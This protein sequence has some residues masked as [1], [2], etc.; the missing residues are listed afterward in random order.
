LSACLNFAPKFPLVSSIEKLP[1]IHGG[2]LKGHDF[3][4][5]KKCCEMTLGFSR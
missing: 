2:V 4:R 3:N 5:A 1:G